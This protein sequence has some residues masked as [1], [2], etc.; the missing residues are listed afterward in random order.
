MNIA[1][2]TDSVADVPAHIRD[3]LNITVVPAIVVIDGQEYIDGV[4]ITRPEFYQRLAN[5]KTPVT[6]AAPAVGAFQDAYQ[7]LFDQGAAQILAILTTSKLS[8]IYNSARVAAQSFQDRVQVVDSTQLSLGIGFQVMA[9]AEAAAAGEPMESLLARAA[10]VRDQVQ[11]IAMLDTLEYVHR[12]GRVSWAKASLGNLLR[13]KAFVQVL[14]GQVLQSGQ[15][16]TRKKGLLHLQE[17]LAKL[18][19]LER[20]AILHTHAEEEARQILD[21]HA[22]QSAAP[23]F[24]VYV[25]PPL[26]TH[27]GP[28]GLGFAALPIKP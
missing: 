12:S 14:D 8:G 23:P 3:E 5:A 17:R 21:Q 6:S 19:P 26:G 11:V 15:T 1:I 25:N 10:Q 13:L 24:L 4:T 16:R 27:V 28:N 7:K 22:A 20:L 18:G 2:L 9:A